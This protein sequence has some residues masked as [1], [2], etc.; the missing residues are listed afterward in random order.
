MFALVILVGFFLQS[1]AAPKDTQGVPPPAPSSA[2]VQK[3]PDAD[4]PTALLKVKRIYVDS[5]GEDAISRELQSMVVS[6]LVATRRFKV[7][8]NREKADAILKGAALEKSSQEVHAYGESTS[9]GSAAGGSHGEVS[10]SVVNGNGSISGSS[11]G[12]FAARHMGISDSSVN[13]E[14]IDRARISIRLVNP[15]GDVIWTTTQESK[16][17]KYKGASA[18]VADQC[19]KQLLRDVTKLESSTAA[20]P[21]PTTSPSSPAH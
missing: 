5:F 13:T 9:V 8:E 20:T 12:G 1:A 3:A 18:D 21:T 15:D 14:T 4:D 10:G 16:G 2:A 17:A 7:T 6:S 19:V 11:S